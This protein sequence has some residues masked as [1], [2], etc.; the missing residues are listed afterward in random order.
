MDQTAMSAAAE[1]Q[2]SIAR[3]M[4][5]LAQKTVAASAKVA[6]GAARWVSPDRHRKVC[7]W[8]EGT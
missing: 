6:C 7:D 1:I 4:V 8:E 3:Q 5:Y 2:Y